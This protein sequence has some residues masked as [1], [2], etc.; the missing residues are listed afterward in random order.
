MKNGNQI[1]TLYWNSDRPR[2]MRTSREPGMSRCRSGIPDRFSHSPA[3]QRK[4]EARTQLINQAYQT[5]ND[6]AGTRALRVTR[7]SNVHTRHDDDPT[8][9]GPL[10]LLV[11]ASSAARQEPRGPQS[12]ITIARQGQPKSLV[13]A[14]HILVDRHELHPY[15]FEGLV[16]IAGNH[17]IRVCRQA[18]MR[19]RKRQIFSVLNGGVW[20]NSNTIFSN[21]SDNRSRF[22]RE[23]EPL[24]AFPHRFLVIE[25]AIQYNK[26]AG[27][28]ANII[29][30][31]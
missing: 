15:E 4:A 3:L 30:P 2:R 31:G 22:L 9:S 10:L 29:R 18:T 23:L 11:T 27:V 20:K 12:L 17:L 1:T 24:L 13:Q 19:L 21:P 26:G 7:Q 25:G 28:W 6:P 16:R 5:L 8:R 14:V